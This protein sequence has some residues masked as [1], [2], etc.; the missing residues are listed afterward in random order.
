[1]LKEKFNIGI[2]YL[3]YYQTIKKLLAEG[4]TSGLNHSDAMIKYTKMNLQRM[5]RIQKSFKIDKELEEL[6]K[7]SDNPLN[8]LVLAEAWCGD[9]AQNLPIINNIVEFN[10]LWNMKIVWRDEN[11]DLM[12]KYLTN[13]SI[14]IP[15]VVIMDDNFNE[16]SVW[17]PRPKPCQQL[18]MDYKADPKGVPYMDFVETVHLWYAKDRGM[19]LQ[20]E[21][22]LLLSSFS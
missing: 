3:E 22:K 9:V 12:N 1:M 8:F 19:A 16:L 18:V 10:P 7:I 17:G 14:S 2:S 15:K 6:V 5:N 13:G 20:Q 11:L 21:W 4:K